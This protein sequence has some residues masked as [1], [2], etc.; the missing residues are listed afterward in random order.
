MWNEADVC[1]VALVCGM[2]LGARVSK[3]VGS[4][5]AK[6]AE[7]SL[8]ATKTGLCVY[9]Q[10][11]RESHQLFVPRYGGYSG[12]FKFIFNKLSK[13]LLMQSYTSLSLRPYYPLQFHLCV[14]PPL[15]ITTFCSI[16]GA[17]L[18]AP[19]A[20]TRSQSVLMQITLP[21]EPHETEP[22]VLVASYRGRT[23]CVHCKQ[24]TRHTS[25]VLPGPRVSREINTIRIERSDALL[26]Y[27]YHFARLHKRVF[28]G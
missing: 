17:L 4:D 20:S 1:N 11:Y 14:L 19:E 23:A 3:A 16:L 10:K 13:I 28:I 8:F 12:A 21:Q 25:R 18:D 2:L 15:D 6:I 24:C 27:F 26:G 9:S 5:C 7:Y 22:H